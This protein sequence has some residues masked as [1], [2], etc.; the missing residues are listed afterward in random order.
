V[1]RH[2]N[3]KSTIT[4]V[5]S[6]VDPIHHTLKFFWYGEDTDAEYLIGSPAFSFAD[7]EVMEDR[8]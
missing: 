5:D 1:V 4:I 6:L 2:P 3:E 7:V 8:L